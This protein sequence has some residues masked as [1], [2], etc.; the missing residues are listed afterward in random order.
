MSTSGPHEFYRYLHCNMR[1]RARYGLEMDID[2]YR[3]LNQL[4]QKRKVENLRA[5][6]TGDLEGW[7]LLR[8]TW[9]CAHYKVR[10]GLIA[11][12]MPEPPPKPVQIGDKVHNAKSAQ[13]HQQHLEVLEAQRQVRE[14]D[15]K[16]F[17]T[18]AHTVK[19]LVRDMF[20]GD[21]LT[22]LDTMIAQKKNAHPG[23]PPESPRADQ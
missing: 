2:E 5:N 4:F 1:L 6:D 12:F 20:L 22:L 17:K 10:E 16:W 18:Q 19:A 14:L 7:V 13:R 11:T 23:A 21:A 3:T 15:I 9:V 8:G